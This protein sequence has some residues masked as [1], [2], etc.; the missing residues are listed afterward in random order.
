MIAQNASTKTNESNTQKTGHMC[1]ALHVHQ[2]KEKLMKKAEQE[3]Q[4]NEKKN[5]RRRREE[6]SLPLYLSI[7]PRLPPS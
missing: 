6:K 5:K 4:K 2:I 7:P 3:E 1:G